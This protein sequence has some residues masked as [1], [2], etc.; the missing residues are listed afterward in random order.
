MTQSLFPERKSK[1][2]VEATAL[3]QTA[4]E[5]LFD[6]CYFGLMSDRRE[7]FLAHHI[8]RPNPWKIFPGGYPPYFDAGN[9]YTKEYIVQHCRVM[10]NIHQQNA[11]N[12]V[13]ET[14][15]I[16]YLLSM[17]KVIFSERSELEPGLDALYE[18]AGA[19]IFVNSLEAVYPKTDEWLRAHM[20]MTGDSDEIAQE[21]AERFQAQQ[22]RARRLYERIQNNVTMLAMAMKEI[23][24]HPQFIHYE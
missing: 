9:I 2:S 13:L 4:E 19:V 8:P 10:W 6:I 11:S 20:R 7:H 17:G 22:I 14:H 24:S 15:R 21:K 12:T 23:V 3:L 5:Y 16:N 18:E 1:K